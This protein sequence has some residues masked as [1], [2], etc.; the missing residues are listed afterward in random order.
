MKE[1]F[2]IFFLKWIIL[3]IGNNV[4]VDQLKRK[5]CRHSVFRMFFGGFF[6]LEFEMQSGENLFLNGLLKCLFDYCRMLIVSS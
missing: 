1:Y 5:I 3:E 2:G 6:L 4:A